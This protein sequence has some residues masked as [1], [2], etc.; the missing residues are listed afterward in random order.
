MHKSLKSLFDADD[1]EKILGGGEVVSEYA[2]PWAVQIWGHDS[3]GLEKMF[4]KTFREDFVENGLT[5]ELRFIQEGIKRKFA[6]EG[7][8]GTIVSA[9]NVITSAHFV[10]EYY[11]VVR[12]TELITNKN[13][14]ADPD[15]LES[16]GVFFSKLSDIQIED[17]K[18]AI[19]GK[20]FR[21]IIR[22]EEVFVL[23]GL[24]LQE[25]LELEEFKNHKNRRTAKKIKYHEK[26]REGVERRNPDPINRLL[27]TYDYAIITLDEPLKF[28]E[29]IQPACLPHTQTDMFVNRVAITSGWGGFGHPTAN[30][31]P[32]L[33]EARLKVW[34][35]ED[36]TVVYQK[37]QKEF[38]NKL[39]KI[40]EYER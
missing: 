10:E 26:F 14:G 21:N 38:D 1:L 3:I 33:K 7:C 35:N 12:I 2:Q 8:A 24:H 28:T 29:K 6:P 32:K 25:W 27:T 4:T 30:F 11:D 23:V 22:E 36:C 34:S 5:N 17:I 20:G 13:F 15:F 19:G 31:A 18:R 16:I 39:V 9:R 37:L 40:T